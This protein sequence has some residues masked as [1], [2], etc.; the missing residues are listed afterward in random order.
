MIAPEPHVIYHYS[1][2]TMFEN[3]PTGTHL[4]RRSLGTRYY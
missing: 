3:D 1:I 2:F 4:L